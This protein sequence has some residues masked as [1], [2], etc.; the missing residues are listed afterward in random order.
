MLTLNDTQE[1]IVR[2]EFWSKSGQPASCVP[3]VPNVTPSGDSFV[4]AKMLSN[5][6]TYHSFEYRLK[7]LNSGNCKIIVESC[8]I[9]DG[10]EVPVSGTFDVS[11]T[12]SPASEIV[13]NIDKIEQA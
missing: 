3:G 13:F 4:A 10:K 7:P 6:P 5:D 1:A 11:V 12:D 8:S 9:V 2:F